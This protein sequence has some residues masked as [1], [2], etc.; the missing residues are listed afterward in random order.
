MAGIDPSV[1]P[2]G[3]R[4]EKRLEGPVLT[5]AWLALPVVFLSFSTVDGPWATVT[6]LAAWVIWAVFLA[7]A[8][9]MLSVAA[10][11][12]AWARGHVFGL[13][14]LAV[15]FPLL[16]KLLEALLA[17]RALTSVQGLR[18]LQVL[19]VAK[20]LKILKSVLI[21]K[22][23]GRAPRNPVAVAI[24]CLAL[25]VVAVGIGHRITTGEKSTTPVHGFYDVV[26]ELPLLP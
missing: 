15:T 13:L 9:I 17:A 26:E 19:Y 3:A 12:R 6:V 23:K 20:A 22:G 10:D 18:I 14:V 11:R 5:A 8:V 1:D 4:W 7:E 2:R 24:G 21:V 25:A 16:T